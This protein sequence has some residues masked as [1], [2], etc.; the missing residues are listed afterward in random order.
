MEEKYYLSGDV[1][2]RLNVSV[3]MVRDY[4]LSGKLK[5]AMLISGRYVIAESEL[6]RFETERLTRKNN[7]VA[8]A[9]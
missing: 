6:K 8:K 1:A 9:A 3:K 5:L 7:H 2:K 4:I